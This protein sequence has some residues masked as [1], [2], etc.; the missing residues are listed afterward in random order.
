MCVFLKLFFQ[1]FDLV[2]ISARDRVDFG[3]V[4]SA[5]SSAQHQKGSVYVGVRNGLLFSYRVKKAEEKLSEMYLSLEVRNKGSDE[6]EILS[7]VKFHSNI[8]FLLR[9]LKVISCVLHKC[10]C[11]RQ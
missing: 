4:H 1:N 2:I 11:K 8:F 10:P 6:G 3:N 7:Q 5:E 9:I